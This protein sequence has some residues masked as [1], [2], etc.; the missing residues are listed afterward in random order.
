MA[1]TFNY[2]ESI[3]MISAVCSSYFSR[4]EIID[5]FSK[6]FDENK[7]FDQDEV[8]QIVRDITTEKMISSK[9]KEESIR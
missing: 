1:R 9:S 3:N 4:K 5:F 2:K 6:N 7:Q 8:K